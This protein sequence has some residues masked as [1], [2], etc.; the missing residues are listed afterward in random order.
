MNPRFV[1]RLP[2]LVLSLGAAAV[3]TMTGCTSGMVTN[4][5]Q[6]DAATGPAFLVGTDA[7]LG[8]PIGA[9]DILHPL[10]VSPL[11][12]REMGAKSFLG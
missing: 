2:G 5:S 12:I 3:F 11:K 8:G 1:R 7:P 10:R 9:V 4:G 6:P